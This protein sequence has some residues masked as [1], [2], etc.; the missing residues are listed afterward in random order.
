MA[1]FGENLRRE[2]EMRGITLEEISGTTKISVRLLEALEKEEFSKLPGGIFTR[3]FIRS[4]ANYLG[5]DEEHVMAEYQLAVPPRPEEDLSRV[6]VNSNQPRKRSGAPIVAWLIAGALL[7]GGYGIFRYTHRASEATGSFGNLLSVPAVSKSAVAQPRIPSQPPPVLMP[8]SATAVTAAD[9]PTNTPSTSASQN[10]LG[11]ASV[12]SQA[13]VTGGNP[14]SSTDHNPASTT[15]F[16]STAFIASPKPASADITSL[17]AETGGGLILQVAATEPSW[18]AV[19]ADGKT[20]LERVLSPSE[21]RTLTAKNYFDVTTGNA[22][23]TVLTLNGVTLKPLGRQGEVK[24]LHL[25]RN[26]LRSANP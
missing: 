18:V 13:N 3:S 10:L 19:N 4:Y 15:N 6:G 22:Q 16:S 26:D 11:G 24:T 20:V 9:G 25:T 17:P 5:L 23:G 21:Q 2:R 7:A 8:Q 12:R 14:S 1:G